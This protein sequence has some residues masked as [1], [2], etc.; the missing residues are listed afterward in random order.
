MTLQIDR[1]G[2][3][4]SR[5]SFRNMARKFELSDWQQCA[6]HDMPCDDGGGAKETSKKAVGLEVATLNPA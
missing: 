4:T 5:R 1:K 6:A 2:T 3:V